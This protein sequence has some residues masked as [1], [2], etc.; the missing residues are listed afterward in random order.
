LLGLLLL[1]EPGVDEE[2]PLLRQLTGNVGVTLPGA[3]LPGSQ[4]SSQLQSLLQGSTAAGA[5]ASLSTSRPVSSCWPGDPSSNA[6]SLPT[7]M[8]AD[9]LLGVRASSGATVED[10]GASEA[11][12]THRDGVPS[13]RAG[14]KKEG[15][16][17]DRG[18]KSKKRGGSSNRG[19]SEQAK[20]SQSR[21]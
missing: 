12:G 6:G 21:Q 10:G 2:A 15:G 19:K 5:G 3:Q 1:V 4:L 8:Q 7:W 14:G 13:M 9:T 16:S 11:A 18:G 20:P 17:S